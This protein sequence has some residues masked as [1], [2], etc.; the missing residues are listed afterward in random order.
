MSGPDID[1]RA[2]LGLGGAALL[3][4]AVA[5]AGITRSASGILLFDPGSPK[6]RAL[7]QEVRGQR[8]VALTGDPVRLWRDKLGDTTGPIGGITTWSDYVILR[9]LAAEQGLRVRSEEHIAVLGNP[10]LVRWMAA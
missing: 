6:A 8:L 4:P 10:M 9:G 2:A 5:S 7:A 1:R 3:A